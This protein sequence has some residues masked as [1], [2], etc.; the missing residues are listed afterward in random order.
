MDVSW[1]RPIRAKIFAADLTFEVLFSPPGE[2]FIRGEC[3]PVAMFTDGKPRLVLGALSND[4]LSDTF[5]LKAVLRDLYRETGLPKNLLRV[6][7]NAQF[8]SRGS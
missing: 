3:G 8:G 5:A 6:E 7:I 2:F 4:A 1:N